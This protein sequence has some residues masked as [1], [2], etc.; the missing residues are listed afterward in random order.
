M[1]HTKIAVAVGLL[2]LIVAGMFGFTYLKKQEITENPTPTPSVEEESPYASITRIDAKHFYENGTHTIV[3][4]IMLPTTCDLLN[5]GAQVQESMPET[6]VIDFTVINN[7]EECGAATVPQRFQVS[8]NASE[9]AVVRATLQ[10]RAVELNLVPPAPGET[11][12]DF[13]LFIKG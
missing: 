13:E 2:V 6:A 7:A 5:W 12:E 10:G 1:E 4:E 3:G 9:Q 11:P 8:F